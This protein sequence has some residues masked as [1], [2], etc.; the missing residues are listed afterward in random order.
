MWSSKKRTSSL[1][2]ALHVN[3]KLNEF[4]S[5]SGF[6]PQGPTG[7]M[8]IQ[9]F[10]GNTTN[11]GAT[12]YTGPTGQGRVGPIGQRGPQG[13][14][15]TP[16]SII[17]G[18]AKTTNSQTTFLGLFKNENSLIDE[19]QVQYAMPFSGTLSKFYVILNKPTITGIN[20][21]SR[22]FTIRKNE[23]STSVTVTFNNS[24]TTITSDTIN[25]VSFSEGD[26][27]SVSSACSGTTQNDIEVRWTALF[28]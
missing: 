20:T 14:T 27:L 21:G 4:V 3:N 2:N 23:I 26:R 24:S 11:T 9:G 28:S 10:A 6:G 17:G 13:P 15:G 8:G 12:G 5:N 19:S 16:K 22:T 25:T 7:P 18:S 1:S